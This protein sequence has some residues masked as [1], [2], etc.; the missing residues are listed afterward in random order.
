MTFGST[1]LSLAAD[2]TSVTNLVADS[3]DGDG[4]AALDFTGQGGASTVEFTV[5][6][7]AAFDSTVG[8]YLVDDLTGQVTFND[9]TF[10]VGDAGYAEA[11]LN[12]A[13]QGLSLS[14]GN[15]ESTT[16]TATI[17]DAL[18]GLYITVQDPNFST[19]QTYFSFLSANDDSS[20]HVKLLGSNAIGFEDLSGLGDADFNDLVLSFSVSAA[21]QTPA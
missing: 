2:D 7:E 16:T 6:R 9:Q 5:F 21:V 8:L 11:A 10:Q 18:F 17:D 13:V 1:T 14:T 3:D 15:G 4:A 20:D 19:D 12:R